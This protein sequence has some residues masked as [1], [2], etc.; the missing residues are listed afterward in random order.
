MYDFSA[1]GIIPLVSRQRYFYLSAWIFIKTFWKD[2]MRKLILPIALSVTGLAIAAD[3]EVHGSVNM[4]YATYFDDEF[5]PKNAGNQDIDLSLKANLDENVS[6]VVKGTTH[7]TFL[8]A[9][10][11]KEASEI[12]HGFARSAAMGDDGRYTSFD[13]D[14]AQLR[15]DVSHDVSFIFGDMTYSAGA[16]NYYFW[17]DPARYAVIARET[18]LRG[19][20]AEF[21]NEKYGNGKFYMGAS[22]ENSHTLDVFGSYSLMLLNRP[23]EHFVLT[24]SIEWMFGTNIGRPYTY[25]LGTEIDYSKNLDNMNYGVYA[26]WGLHPYKGRGVHSFLIEPSFNYSVFNLGMSF[27]YAMVDKDYEPGDQIFTDDQKMF[28]VEPSFNLHK[29]VTL[30]VS[31]EY[32]DPDTE[33]SDDQFHFLGMNLYVYPTLKTQVTFWFGY[34]FTEEDS[35]T[36][37]GDTH[38]SMGISASAEF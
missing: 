14:G 38:F 26:V 2:C 34:N 22:D 19:V 3:I 15:W 18:S 11:K 29:K 23:N 10:G 12:R 37:A 17:R 32:H 16:F 33:T 4:D 25:T 6:V 36:L 20:G 30:G 24:P 27:F 8:N 7:S 31:Y 1:I 21:G 5:D 13:F 35:E 28:S 9:K